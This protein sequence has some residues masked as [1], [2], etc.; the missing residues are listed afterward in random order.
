MVFRRWFD[1]KILSLVNNSRNIAINYLNDYQKSIV[2]DLQ[3]LHTIL[4][5]I[6]NFVI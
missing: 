4:I 2:K 5:E 3:L 6:K 1:D